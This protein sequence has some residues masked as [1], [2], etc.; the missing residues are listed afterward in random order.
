MLCKRRWI[1]HVTASC[2]DGGGAFSGHGIV[3]F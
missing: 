1:V 2:L 3:T